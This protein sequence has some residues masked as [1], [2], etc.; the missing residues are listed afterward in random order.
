MIE[1]EAETWYGESLAGRAVGSA[2]D[3]IY[4]AADVPHVVVNRSDR[5][6]RAV[7]VHGAADDQEGIVLRP[8]LDSL[9]P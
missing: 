9:V 1:G 7:V 2:G 3:Y 4:I 6:C 5:P 8:D